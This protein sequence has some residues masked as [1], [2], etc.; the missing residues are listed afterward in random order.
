MVIDATT[1]PLALAA[2]AALTGGVAAVW[3]ALQCPACKAEL[4]ATQAELK[5]ERLEHWKTAMALERL[6]GKY[7]RERGSDSPPPPK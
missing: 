4:A 2:L 1:G 5:A 3:K 7:E 6:L